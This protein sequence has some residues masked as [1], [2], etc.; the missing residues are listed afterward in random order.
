MAKEMDSTIYAMQ[1][2]KLT[3]INLDNHC[4]YAS[5]KPG[6]I[7]NAKDIGPRVI[8]IPEKIICKKKTK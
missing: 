8:R 3:L 1:E 2:Y 4:I 7:E 5:L 6:N